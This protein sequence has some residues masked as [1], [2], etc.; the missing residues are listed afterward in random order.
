MLSTLFENGQLNS[1]ENDFWWASLLCVC[2]NCCR[3]QRRAIN[4]IN[5]CTFSS[6]LIFRYYSSV[7]AWTVKIYFV[8][9]VEC[10]T[11]FYVYIG[12][13][14]FVDYFT[15]IFDELVKCIFSGYTRW[16]AF[17][18]QKN[19]RRSSINCILLQTYF[20]FL[21][22]SLTSFNWRGTQCW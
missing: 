11:E 17:Q 2:T 19:T 12:E 7:V 15:F 9:Y 16:L 10:V 5:I 13:G 18:L 3:L 22:S 4:S 21:F 14:F 8:G 6:W 20:S 1:F